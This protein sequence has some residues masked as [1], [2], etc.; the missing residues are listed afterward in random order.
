MK[1]LFTLAL[2][3]SLA[4]HVSQAQDQ[5]KP[6]YKK[7]H[8]GIGLE[9]ALPIGAFG[10]GY[11]VGVGSTIRA[12]FGLNEKL[13][14]T[15]TSGVMAFMPKTISGIDMKAQLNIPYKAGV[16]YM[17]TKKVYGLGEVGATTARVYY[18]TTSGKLVSA[19]STSFTY[20][21]NIGTHLGKFDASLRYEGYRSSGFIGLRL[22]FNF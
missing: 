3:A 22:G 21:T 11:T 5:D 2:I 4:C 17:L 10:T 9:S 16:K 6:S 8:L 12:T 7:F 15:A 13:A 20:A 14:L 1:R 19:S 18:P